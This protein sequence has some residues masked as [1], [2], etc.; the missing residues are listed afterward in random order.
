MT[1]NGFG[2]RG[3]IGETYREHGEHFRQNPE[4]IGR[5]AVH[6]QDGDVSGGS[7]PDPESR[8]VAFLFPGATCQLSS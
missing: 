4:R 6:P 8:S 7:R 5:G 2:S 1:A 3:V